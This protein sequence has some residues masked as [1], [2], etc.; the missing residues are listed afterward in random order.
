MPGDLV[1]FN[2]GSGGSIGHVGI[3]IGGGQI[4]HSANSRT[5]VKTD[6]INSGYYYKYYYSARR[7]VK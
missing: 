7:I 6:T 1:F 2:N 3:Y 5:G 4:V